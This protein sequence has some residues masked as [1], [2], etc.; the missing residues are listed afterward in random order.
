MDFNAI[1]RVTEAMKKLLD[2]ALRAENNGANSVFVGPLDDP[3]A[4]D[5]KMVLFLYRIAV[6]ADLRR[7]LHEVIAPQPDQPPVTHENS[8]PLDLYYL[9]TAGTQTAGGELTDLSLLGRAMQ[10][11]NDSPV[12]AGP[13]VQNETVWITLDAVPSEEMGRI[14]SL[15][16]TVNYRTSVVYLATPVWIDPEQPPTGSAPVVEEPHLVGQV[17]R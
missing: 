1:S 13:D 10:A 15:F 11:L 5:A 2:Q 12:L 4:A 8:L 14:W 9:I 7:G 6:N 3:S 17:G 16:P